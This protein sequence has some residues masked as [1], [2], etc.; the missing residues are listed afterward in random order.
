MNRRERG[1]LIA[2]VIGNG[3]FGFSFMFS[4]MAL[5]VTNPPIL[6]MYRFVIAFVLIN[7]VALWANKSG[8]TGWLRFQLRAKDA[9]S[10]L[11]LGICQPVIYFLCENYGVSLTNSTVSGVIIA[12]I[13]IAALGMGALFLKEYP[14]P[15]QIFFALLSI[16]GV[17]VLT[18]QQSAQGD[19]KALG[20]LLL[21]GAVFIG[22][23]YN[24]ISRKTSE[25]FSALERTYVMMGLGAA[26]FTLLAVCQ[27]LSAP[28][29]LV[30]PL[31]KPQFLLSLTYLS[32][33][34][35]IV[36]FLMLNY[37]N[38][39]LPIAR[40][41]AFCNLT[42]VIS[43]FAGVIFLGE[44]FEWVSLIAS[45]VIIAGVWGVQKG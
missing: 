23:I 41:T 8:R 27:N 24:I 45:V 35:S 9:V 43:V 21:L 11:P 4:R 12:L 20:V 42:T 44:P 13:P 10:L 5:E 19:V 30:R 7:L 39:E 33:L 36:A 15:A 16:A 1:G 34:S 32:G 18:L 40:A 31:G 14:K 26:A 38:S 29:A 37:A 17:T 28:M 22:V 6:L 25:R 3:I 2:A